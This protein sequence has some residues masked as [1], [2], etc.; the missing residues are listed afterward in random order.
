MSG[1]IDDILVDEA[2]NE[3][4]FAKPELTEFSLNALENGYLRYRTQVN[5]KNNNVRRSNV[6]TDTMIH[7]IGTSEGKVENEYFVRVDGDNPLT[8]GTTWT[9]VVESTEPFVDEI[10]WKVSLID[11]V[12]FELKEK[13]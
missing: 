2:K 6:Y 11:S 13:A 8:M 10:A 12:E 3:E 9:T 1:N 4:R 7:I 5:I